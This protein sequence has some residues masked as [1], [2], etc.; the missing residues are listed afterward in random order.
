MRYELNNLRVNNKL[1][2]PRAEFSRESLLRE[3]SDTLQYAWDAIN[4]GRR[5]IPLFFLFFNQPT[6]YPKM[7]ANPSLVLNKV[8]D[9]TFE[10]YEVPLLTDPNDVLVQVKKTGICGSDI[11]YYTHGR[12]GDFVLTKPMVLGHESAGVVV[13]VGKGVT[14]LKVGDKV[15]IEPGVPSRTSD[16]YKS[17]HYNLCPHMCF[18]ATPNSNPDEPNPPG[19]LCKY[20]KSPADFLV[21]LPEHV[22]LELGAMVE[23][24][25]VGVHASRLGRVTFGDHVVVFG[26]G[27][28]GILAAAVARKFGAA[29][30]TIV[31]IFDSKLELAKSIGAAT[32]TFNSMTEGVLSEALPA[33]VRP[34]VVLECTGAEIC[35]QQGVLALK[36]GGRHVQVGNAGSYLKFPITEFVTK[37]L[38]LFGSF[39]YGYNDY[40]TSVAIL[41]ENYK[42]GKENA[43]VDFEA[44]ITH[45]FPFKN[46][47]EAYDAVRAG[48]GAVKCIIDG[49][50]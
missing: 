22:S 26:A 45:R 35:V 49:P 19:T 34:D 13:E 46:A 41:D 48:D 11:H 42:N 37:E 18:A 47:I 36:A 21:K 16:E 17:G 4:Y 50:E 6:P 7:P 40:K 30:V 8:N 20:Y 43:L 24:L 15:A 23:P 3:D 2:F 33:G 44:L 14:D 10:N 29:S 27:P 28:V 32:H 31:D 5:R 12:I 25:T 39:R 38:T 9:I 1:G